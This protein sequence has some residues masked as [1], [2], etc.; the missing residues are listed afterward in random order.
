MIPRYSS[1]ISSS[2]SP[3]FVGKKGE[4]ELLR[5]SN[6]NNSKSNSSYKIPELYSPRNNNNNSLLNNSLNSLKSLSASSYSLKNS[7]NMM[8]NT[9]RSSKDYSTLL[10]SPSSSSPSLSSYKR[11]Y[12]SSSPST[13][14]TSP[15]PTT[16]S[17]KKEMFESCSPLNT[18]YSPKSSPNRDIYKSMYNCPYCNQSFYAYTLFLDHTEKCPNRL[19]TNNLNE[20]KKRNKENDKSQST[21]NSSLL[22]STSS[23]FPSS[24]T[25]TSKQTVKQTI[26]DTEFQMHTRNGTVIKKCF[27]VASKEDELTFGTNY[28]CLCICFEYSIQILHEMIDATAW[29]QWNSEMINELL[30]S[31]CLQDPQRNVFCVEDVYKNVV[32]FNRQLRILKRE[33]SLPIDLKALIPKLKRKGLLQCNDSS[34]SSTINNNIKASSNICCIFHSKRTSIVVYCR[35]SEGEDQVFY[36][37][38]DPHAQVTDGISHGASITYLINDSSLYSY[39][40]K[41]IFTNNEP[42]IACLIVALQP[43]IPFEQFTLQLLEEDNFN[44]TNNNEEQQQLLKVTTEVREWKAKLEMERKANHDLEKQLNSQQEIIQNLKKELEKYSSMEEERNHQLK[45]IENL[46]QL[47]SFVQQSILK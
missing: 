47:L 17:R 7:N 4:E 15:S 5:K 43:N 33:K 34:S 38:F 24:T 44:N 3:K 12:Y 11:S 39:L 21:F 30:K 8:T 27:I 35:V 42:C 9:N 31:G 40:S 20:E 2:S 36:I 32:R 13:K 18:I 41:W 23:S 46:K 16:T 1:P 22:L 25:F 45:E 19:S 6:N 26:K 29:D 10:S 28:S 37:A 14:T